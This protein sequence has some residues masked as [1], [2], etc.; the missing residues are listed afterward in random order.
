MRRCARARAHA[1]LGPPAGARRRAAAPRPTP[2]PHPRACLC[3]PPPP[4]RAS[5]GEGYAAQQPLLSTKTIQLFYR[6]LSEQLILLLKRLEL[7]AEPAAVQALDGPSLG[8]A[9]ESVAQAVSL[10]SGLLS[11]S[12]SLDK[13]AAFIASILR[14]RCAPHARGGRRAPCGRG[15]RAI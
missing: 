11:P 13:Q 2:A 3:P 15:A 14:M 6:P 7:P 10:F 4:P 9:V 1:L 5:A 8:G 12:K